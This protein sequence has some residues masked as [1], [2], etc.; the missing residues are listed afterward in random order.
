M[1]DTTSP[2]GARASGPLSRTGVIGLSVLVAMTMTAAVMGCDAAV[3][4]RGPASSRPSSG[5]ASAP[6]SPSPSP[7]STAGGHPLILFYQTTP[8]AEFAAVPAGARLT[9]LQTAASSRDG[10]TLYLGFEIDGGKCGTYEV[11][12]EPKHKAMD[13]G[14]IHLPAPGQACSMQ[15]TAVNLVVRLSSPLGLRPVVD[16]ATGKPVVAYAVSTAEQGSDGPPPP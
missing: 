11:V 10:L 13:A 6:T 9:A 3:Q 5:A 15:D 14:V 1:R 2:A 16:L 7:G 12:L 4:T 8:R